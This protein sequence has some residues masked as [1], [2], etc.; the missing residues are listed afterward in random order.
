MNRVYMGFRDSIERMESQV[1]KTMTKMNADP[2][3]R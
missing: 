2:R 3:A 1:E